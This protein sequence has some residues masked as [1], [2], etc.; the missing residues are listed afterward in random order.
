MASRP[1]P[2]RGDLTEGPVLR[3]LLLFSLPALMSGI[4]ESRS[5]ASAGLHSFA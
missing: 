5:G 4:V 2:M 1:P 3:T